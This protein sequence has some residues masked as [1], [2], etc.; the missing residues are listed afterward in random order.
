[1]ATGQRLASPGS[2]DPPS[3]L[4]LSLLLGVPFQV[5]SSS[6]VPGPGSLS[7]PCPPRA[8][9]RCRWRRL[10]GCAEHV[11][12]ASLNPKS[13]PSLGRARVQS[14]IIQFSLSISIPV[15]IAIFNRLHRPPCHSPNQA[16]AKLLT[17]QEPIHPS[18]IHPSNTHHHH[19]RLRHR[20]HP[21]RFLDALVPSPN[22]TLPTPA[23]TSST[24][25]CNTSCRNPR[26]HRSSR[27]PP[28]T[29]RLHPLTSPTASPNQP[30]CCR[31]MARP[32]MMA[33][34]TTLA[35]PMPPPSP[36]MPPKPLL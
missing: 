14:V 29:A 30:H 8:H 26:G 10:R 16:T 1:M 23:A 9:C 28:R 31:A 20:P 18:S 21:S 32:A 2:E 33:T 35:L 17:A 19:H 27:T 13:P 24:D 5:T 12:A 11:R 22:L 15:S 4:V 36:Q 25:G 3:P 6:I 7:R 34:A